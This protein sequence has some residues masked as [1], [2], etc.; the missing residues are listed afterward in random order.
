MARSTL[1]FVIQ[2]G[3]NSADSRRIEAC[4]ADIERVALDLPG[5][6]R[7]IGC[8]RGL[9]GAQGLMTCSPARASWTGAGGGHGLAIAAWNGYPGALIKWVLGA[10]WRGWT[11]PPARCLGRPGRRGHSGPVPV[12]WARHPPS[13]DRRV[14]PSPIAR[15]ASMASAGTASFSRTGRPRLT[16]KCRARPRCGSR[17]APALQAL[18][19]YLIALGG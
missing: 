13:P 17:C 9:Q 1:Y 5:S 8:R 7:S 15:A 14:A 11:L 18:Q 4:P 19:D 16:E 2:R 6:R 10:R 3:G 12:R